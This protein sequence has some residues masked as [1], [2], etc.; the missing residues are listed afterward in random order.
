MVVILDA[1]LHLLH[2]LVHQLHF[3]VLFPVAGNYAAFLIEDGSAFDGFLEEGWAGILSDVDFAVVVD[4]LLGEVGCIHGLPHVLQKR[5]VIICF[6]Y[7]R[8]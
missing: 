4:G 7:A 1:T 6:H 2:D 5:G 3:L 8:C